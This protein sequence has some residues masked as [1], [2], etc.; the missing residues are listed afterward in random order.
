MIISDSRAQIFLVGSKFVQQ[1]AKKRVLGLLVSFGV[2][3]QDLVRELNR[4]CLTFNSQQR[5]YD[6]CNITT[7][8]RRKP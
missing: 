8:P 4:R 7:A 6:A 5:L 1:E 3:L 2:T